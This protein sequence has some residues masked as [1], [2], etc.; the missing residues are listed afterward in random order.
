[1]IVYA[2]MNQVDGKRYIGST[3]NTFKYRYGGSKW[4]NTTH[5]TYLK[6]AA[7][8]YGPENFKVAILFETESFQE[9]VEKEIE[10]IS[11][12]KTY[13]REFGYNIIKGYGLID[14]KPELRE[15]DE[16][17]KTRQRASIAKFWN[18]HP[19]A[20]QKRK[21]TTTALWQTEEYSQ[22][23]K[24]NHQKAVQTA[25]FKEKAS[26][27]SKTQWANV[28]LRETRL[29]NQKIAM[30]TPEYA[31]KHRQ[32]GLNRLKEPQALENLLAQHS[33]M[34]ND[35]LIQL[36]L[37]AMHQE[38]YRRKK[39]K[40]PFTKRHKRLYWDTYKDFLLWYESRRLVFDG[41]V[42]EELE[43]NKIYQITGLARGPLQT[44]LKHGVVKRGGAKGKTLKYEETLP[45]LGCKIPIWYKG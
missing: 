1:M 25:E 31:E 20:L 21:E 24:Q 16:E 28:A 15:W 38:T 29:A 11:L 17:T 26:K 37:K 35:P 6:R 23:V 12:Y 9:L 8:K 10:L 40:E 18:N 13:D 4:W 42:I 43:L 5:N 32:N 41:T 7:A 39:N 34:Y 3:I 33:E 22:K 44:A 45:P 27:N 36:K 19:E 30:S 14:T 2:I